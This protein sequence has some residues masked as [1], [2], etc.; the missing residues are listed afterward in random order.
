MQQST[1]AAELNSESTLNCNGK[2]FK[3]VNSTHYQPCSLTERSGQTP[4]YL[5][6]GETLAC[7]DGNSCSDENTVNCAV[8]RTVQPVN[9]DQL[10]QIPVEVTVVNEQPAVSVD[11]SS[12]TEL[13][14]SLIADEIA[15]PT[16]A[17]V[18]EP[19]ASSVAPTV[20]PASIPKESAEDAKPVE[21]TP[22]KKGINTHSQE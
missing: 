12:E 18:V 9:N 13:A 14:K 19:A 11:K 21:S 16:D 5:I 4:Q 8:A 15:T 6:N 1:Q 2:D 10:S 17:S 7:L 20:A 3:C 22:A